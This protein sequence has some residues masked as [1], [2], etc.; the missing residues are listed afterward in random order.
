MTDGFRIEAGSSCYLS[1]NTYKKN[2]YER[3]TVDVE[4]LEIPERSRCV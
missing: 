3:K 4:F 2:N 1:N